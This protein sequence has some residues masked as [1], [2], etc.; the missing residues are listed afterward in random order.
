M[1]EVALFFSTL[2]DFIIP[3][4][5]KQKASANPNLTRCKKFSICNDEAEAG[6]WQAFE[7]KNKKEF[8]LLSAPF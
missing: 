8:A 7:M 5:K 4:F 3:V 6:S 1:V 2:K